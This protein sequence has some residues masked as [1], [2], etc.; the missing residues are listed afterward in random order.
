MYFLT[1]EISPVC[2]QDGVVVVCNCILWINPESLLIVPRSSRMIVHRVCE[3]DGVVVVCDCILWVNPESRVATQ[4]LPM[5]SPVATSHTLAVLSQEPDASFVP[6]G[7]QL[8]DKTLPVWPRSG[9]PMASPWSGT[10][11]AL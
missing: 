2:E 6:S 5:A 3:Q 4:L 11:V 1:H 9:S 8:T 7:L 10:L